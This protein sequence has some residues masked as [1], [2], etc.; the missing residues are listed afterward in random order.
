MINRYADTDKLF[1][2]EMKRIRRKRDKVMENLMR[3]RRFL[4]FEELVR[5]DR[6]CP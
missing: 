5:R 3:G 6:R 4:S 2:S 1:E